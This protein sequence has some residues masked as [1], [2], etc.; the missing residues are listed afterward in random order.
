[1]IAIDSLSAIR[2]FVQ[3]PFVSASGQAS[4]G[5][6]ARIGVSIPA[7]P[8]RRRCDLFANWLL[9]LRGVNW[10]WRCHKLVVNGPPVLWLRIGFTN[11]TVAEGIF[12]DWQLRFD[13]IT[14]R[15]TAKI[16]VLNRDCDYE[17]PTACDA[18]QIASIADF[19]PATTTTSEKDSVK[20]A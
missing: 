16:I 20:K 18:F 17:W 5:N 6:T 19:D 3:N 10:L 9:C 15:F 4:R 14:R 1:M 11:G 8:V 2:P 7:K 13:P 12:K